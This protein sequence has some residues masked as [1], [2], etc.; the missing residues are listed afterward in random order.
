M[1]SAK[2]REF[3]IIE[4][5]SCPLCNSKN[6]KFVH[7]VWD[8]RY[9]QPDE[10]DL[11]NCSNCN[12]A[13]LKQMIT[14][15]DTQKLYEKY[16]PH[17]NQQETRKKYN[18][19]Y[20]ITLKTGLITLI[21]TLLRS[22]NLSTKIKKH[23]NVL[24]VGCG[25]GVNAKQIQAKKAFWTGVEVDSILAKQCNKKGLNCFN[26]TIEEF[27]TKEKLDTIILS[28]IVEHI[29]Q[30]I[31]FLNTCKKL[32]TK[33]G[34]ILIALPNYDSINHKIYKNNWLHIH[35]PYHLYHY[36][37][38]SIHYLAKK[39]NL[40]ITKHTTRTP[41]NWFLCQMQFKNPKKGK[42]NKT[43]NM[44]FNILKQIII[45]PYLY[46]IDLFKIGDILIVELKKEN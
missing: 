7:S 31:N 40:K 24:D 30:P 44:N 22:A 10:Y 23:E 17:T 4:N 38:N 43:F 39:T 29:H 37:Y 21:H 35:T 45:F 9:G 15:K 41:S 13:F 34:R 5:T 14:P 25:A 28:Q 2:K 6:I 16:Y 18:K 3:Q 26:G 12:L 1:T 27:K 8:D 32:L 42:I 19:L 33:K 11:M 36:N 46:L 20:N